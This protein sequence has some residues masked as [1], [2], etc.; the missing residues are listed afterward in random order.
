[1]DSRDTNGQKKSKTHNPEI[2]D[3]LVKKC[4][5][6]IFELSVNEIGTILKSEALTFQSASIQ[7]T[8]VKHCS[9]R[10]GETRFGVPKH[11]K[12][13]KIKKNAKHMLR[14]QG[15]WDVGVEF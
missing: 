12:N 6:S 9:G 10:I 13:T 7:P 1:M 15:F 2:D 14:D 4:L 5:T 3:L 11:M 8:P